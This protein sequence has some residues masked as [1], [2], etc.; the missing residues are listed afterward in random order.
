VLVTAI[1]RGLLSVEEAD[2]FK[3]ILEAHHFRMTFT[4][5]AMSVMLL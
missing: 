5:F 2:R 3:A 4:S 1:R